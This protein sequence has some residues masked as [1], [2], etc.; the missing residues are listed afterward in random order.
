MVTYQ[1]QTLYASILASSVYMLDIKFRHSL[2]FVLNF[3]RVF[4]KYQILK[5]LSLCFVVSFTSFV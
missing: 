1:I 5:F 2:G 4:V 3:F